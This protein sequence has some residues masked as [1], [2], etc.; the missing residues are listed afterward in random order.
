MKGT[1]PPAT[2]MPRYNDAMNLLAWLGGAS[3][4]QTALMAL[5]AALPML[6]L[7]LSLCVGVWL[8]DVWGEARTVA[9]AKTVARTETS[10]GHRFRVVQYWGSDFYT[11]ELVYTLPSGETRRGLIDGDASKWWRAEICVDEARRRVAV[12][13]E[14]FPWPREDMVLLREVSLP[15]PATD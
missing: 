7:L 14:S 9:S 3:P 12:N 4:K 6:A 2:Y 5:P 8:P 10:S 13:G 11:V 15:A 1:A